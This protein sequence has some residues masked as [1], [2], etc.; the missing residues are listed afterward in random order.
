MHLKQHSKYLVFFFIAFM[1]NSCT[2]QSRYHKSGFNVQWSMHLNPKSRPIQPNKTDNKLQENSSRVSVIQRSDEIKIQ[3]HSSQ[4]LMDFGVKNPAIFQNAE[5]KSIDSPFTGNIS[6]RH[7]L[8]FSIIPQMDTIPSSENN[9][10]MSKRANK[11]ANLSLIF[12]LASIAGSPL[13]LTLIFGP[14]AIYC[15]MRSKEQGIKKG[16]KNGLKK[17]QWGIALATIALTL[18]VIFILLVLTLT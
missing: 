1:F 16:N 4:A 6:A 18:V 15:G 17:T 12:A 2:I 5:L 11:N 10:S 9:R 3:D 13:L 14:L 8:A 7:D